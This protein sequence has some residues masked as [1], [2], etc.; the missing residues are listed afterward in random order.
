[1]AVS[2]R[3]LVT[4][5]IMEDELGLSSGAGGAK[6]TRR[7]EAVSKQIENLCNRRFDQTDAIVEKQPGYGG[8]AIR[9]DRPPIV[10]IASIVYGDD[11]TL[12]AS[13]Y[14]IQDG[15][16]SGIIYFPYGVTWTGKLKAGVI[17]DT[18]IPGSEEWKYTVTYKG[19]WITPAQAVNESKTAN[20]PEDIVQACID[21][22][23]SAYQWTGRDRSIK[24]RSIMSARTDYETGD[25]GLPKS[26]E[27]LLSPYIIIPVGR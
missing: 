22:V 21:A 15:G 17:T 1:M 13:D 27:A 10:S 9:I 19:G 23:V 5:A 26:V 3:A 14:L 6:L 24:S 20:L 12:D 18:R 8:T 25:S 4:E 7:I 11:T 16:A 2:N